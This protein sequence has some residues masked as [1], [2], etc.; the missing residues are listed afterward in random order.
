MTDIENLP[1]VIKLA[2]ENAILGNYDDSVKHYQDGIN[3][4]QSF[5]TTL[6]TK[7][8]KDS[9]G[10]FLAKEGIQNFTKLQ[11]A[12]MQE[13]TNVKEIVEI[14]ESFTNG[15]GAGPKGGSNN[16]YRRMKT[17]SDNM[18]VEIVT[19]DQNYMMKPPVPVPVQ[20]KQPNFERFGGHE[21]FS[22]HKGGPDQYFGKDIDD[23]ADNGNNYYV[24]N[25]NPKMFEEDKDPDIWDPP[26]PPKYENHRKRE[27]TNWNSNKRK[28]ARRV[29]SVKRPP[30]APP[31]G[32]PKKQAPIEENKRAYDKPWAAGAPKASSGSGPKAKSADSFLYH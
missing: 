18:P 17:H 9:G 20:K 13:L 29:A 31:S 6:S 2:R 16:G 28:P 5:L 25:R 23:Y 8:G 27:K 24:N 4:I 30:V 26:S 11:S 1:N 12:I 15:F 22:H 19:P 32:A 21:P 10:K 7:A 3:T 14:N